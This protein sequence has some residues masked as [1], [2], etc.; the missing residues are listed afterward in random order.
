M[1]SVGIGRRCSKV[2]LV[3]EEHRVLLFS[4]IDRTKPDVPPWWFAVGGGLEPGETPE[5]A[6]IRETCEET[7]LKISDP[8]PVVFTRRFTWDFEGEEYDQDE[9]F[10]LVRT[11]SFEPSSNGWTNTETATIRG[12]RWWSIDELRNADEAVFPEDLATHL[13]RLLND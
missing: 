7:G 13:D 11:S 10:F 4:G 12:H 3:D 6:A 2:L 1:S 8:G 9:W 5:D